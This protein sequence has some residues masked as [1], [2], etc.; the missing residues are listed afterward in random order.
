MNCQIVQK[1]LIFFLEKE[2][3]GAEMKAVQE[4]LDICPNC[5]LFAQEM[6]TAL[7]ILD[8]DRIPEITPFFYT[9]VKAKLENQLEA[10]NQVVHRPLLVRVLQPVAF[11]II[12][13]FG[14][15]GG[16][17]L[18]NTSSSKSVN[19]IAEQELIPYWNDLDTEPIEIFLLD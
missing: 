10:E 18:G 17:R 2:L 11:S 19:V 14:V 9:R 13:L 8:T 1:K 6:K 15:Y 3:S 4:H 16:I 12:L 7:S 5:V